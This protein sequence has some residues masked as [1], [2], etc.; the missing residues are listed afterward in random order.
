MVLAINFSSKQKIRSIYLSIHK[1]MKLLAKNTF[2]FGFYMHTQK[3]YLR[4]RF[5]NQNQLLC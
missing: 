3:N 2:L 4:K 1:N 5:R